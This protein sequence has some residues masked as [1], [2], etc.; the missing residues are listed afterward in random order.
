[1]PSPRSRSAAADPGQ[2]QQLRGVDR[3]AAQDDLARA[4][5]AVLPAWPPRRYSTPTAR[6]P[7]NRT[8]VTKAR[9]ITVRFGRLMTGCR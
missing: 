6:L 5:R 1:M 9:V 4:S 8:L 7:S 2:L 3:A